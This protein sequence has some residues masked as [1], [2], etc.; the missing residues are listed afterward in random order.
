MRSGVFLLVAALGSASAE[1]EIAVLESGKILYVDRFERVDDE[2]TLHITGGGVVT[3]PSELVVNVVPNEI[4][5]EGEDPKTVSLFPQLEDVIDPAAWYGVA[6][7]SWPPSS[8]PSRAATQRG[9]EP[10]ARGSCSSCPRRRRSS[11]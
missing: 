3:V 1:A 2:I 4:V 5:E 11:G 9:L 8:G 6:P 10:G 7:S